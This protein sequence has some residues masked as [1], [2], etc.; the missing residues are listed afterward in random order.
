[1]RKLIL[2]LVMMINV[3]SCTSISSGDLR[4]MKLG[5]SIKE[6]RKDKDTIT[7]V[8]LNDKDSFRDATDIT[9]MGVLTRKYLTPAANVAKNLLTK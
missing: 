3:V 2:I 6:I 9:S 8:E 5:G 7:I 4:I 1:M